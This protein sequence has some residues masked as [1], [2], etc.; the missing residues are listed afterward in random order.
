MKPDPTDPESV[1]VFVD[2][3]PTKITRNQMHRL[4]KALQDYGIKHPE[5]IVL[6]DVLP[7]SHFKSA[8]PEADHAVVRA[9]SNNWNSY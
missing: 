1:I 3:D 5:E 6:F 2:Q 8:G 9:K 7:P 4:R